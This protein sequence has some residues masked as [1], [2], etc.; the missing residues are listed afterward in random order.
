MKISLNEIE[1]FIAVAEYESFNSAASKLGITQP[2]LSRRIKKLEDTLGTKL[3]DRSTRKISVS[4]VGEEFLPEARRMIHSFEKSID[5]IEE[6]IQTRTG[7]VS[8]APNITI[9]ETILPSV[10]EAF[11]KKSPHIR[12][13]IM[14]GA[15]PEVQ[16]RVLHR[17][18]EFAIGQF[19]G[20]HPELEFEPLMDDE[21]LLVCHKEHPLAQKEQIEWSDIK[22]HNFIKLH[23]EKGTLSILEHELGEQIDNLSGDI[24]VGHFNAL[25]GCVGQNLGVSAVPTLVKMKRPD[26]D[27]VTRPITSPSVSRKIG[28]IT[29]RGR[30]LSPGAE[31]L[32]KVFRKHFKHLIRV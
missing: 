22:S 17:E 7:S 26:L 8:F 25:L 20:E 11:R 3:L 29:L 31:S 4:I 5:D 23:S 27:L 2:A 28:I 15:S 19:A 21:F 24:Q 1:A 6:L 32:R 13:K 9:A 14:E 18:A 16:S 12:L 10:I 30:S